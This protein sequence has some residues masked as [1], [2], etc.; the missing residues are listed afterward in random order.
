MYRT[1]TQRLAALP[2]DVAL[3]PGH[4]Y[5]DRPSSTLGVERRTNVYL[6]VTS[7]DGWLRL[8]GHS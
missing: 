4:D 1:L 8:M 2:D 5:A 7:L 6:Q 3:F